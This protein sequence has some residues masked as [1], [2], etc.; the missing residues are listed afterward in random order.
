M[1]IAGCRYA[2]Q[3]QKNIFLRL[4]VLGQIYIDVRTIFNSAQG[5]FLRHEISWIT[6][7]NVL[8]DEMFVCCKIDI[9]FQ[10]KHVA[11][12]ITDFLYEN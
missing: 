1:A 11:R 12:K 8:Y 6:P 9:H 4:C 3:R 2:D 5:N 7:K 10:K